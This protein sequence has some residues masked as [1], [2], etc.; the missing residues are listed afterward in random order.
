MK[1]FTLFFCALTLTAFTVAV[2][3]AINALSVPVFASENTLSIVVDAG[4]GGIDGGVL[5]VRTKKKES[6][7]NLAL[8]LKLKERLSDAGFSVTLT[9]KTDAGL[10]GTTATGFKKRDMLKRKEII[11]D[12]SPDLVLSVHQNFYPTSSVR[13]GQAFYKKEDENGKK[14]ASCVQERLNAFYQTQGVKGRTEAI[15]DYFVLNATPFVSIIVEYGFLSN[16]EDEK[17]LLSSNGQSSLVSAT[18]AGVLEYFSKQS[19]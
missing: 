13:G 6:E 10:Y 1:K 9:R 12:A 11:E 15:G 14:L 5:G 16:P 3:L 2:F 17:L 7:V 8:A 19:A 4:H 18:V